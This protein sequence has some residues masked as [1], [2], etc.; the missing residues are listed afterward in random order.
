MKRKYGIKTIQLDNLKLNST[1]DGISNDTLL[2]SYNLL[3]HAIMIGFFIIKH[4]LLK[5]YLSWIAMYEFN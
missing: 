1:F 2:P 5:Y 3:E 4:L